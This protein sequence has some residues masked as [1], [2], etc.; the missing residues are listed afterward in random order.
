MADYSFMKTGFDNVQDA[1][2]TEDM[3]KNVVSLILTL[4]QNAMK[5]AVTYI[6]HSKR[7]AITPEDL[8]RA[9]MLEMFFYKNRPDLLEEAQK[10]KDEIFD[11]GYEDDG[12]SDDENDEDH[13][14]GEEEADAFA[15][16]KCD[17]A[18]CN[19]LNGIYTRWGNWEPST[20]YEK[21]FKK[22]IENM[23]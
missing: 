2:D 18:M 17:C 11:S 7:N 20:E 19:C 12:E 5:T 14:I 3:K 1:V 8:K 22:H 6:T 13:L 4:S 9:M 23:N 10:I 15:D 21:L 16:S